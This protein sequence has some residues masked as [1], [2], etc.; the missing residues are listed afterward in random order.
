MPQ[1]AQHVTQEQESASKGKLNAIF[2][3]LPEG[4]AQRLFRQ[5][6][7]NL[8]N[9]F[10]SNRSLEFTFIKDL[11]RSPLQVVQPNST[12]EVTDGEA[13][14]IGHFEG[15][16]RPTP[17]RTAPEPQEIQEPSAPHSIHSSFLSLTPESSDLS[18]QSSFL[19]STTSPATPS[20][21]SA[22]DEANAINDEG[23]GQK[24]SS[25]RRKRINPEQ[26]LKVDDF[27]YSPPKSI[28][29]TEEQS[30]VEAEPPQPL[31]KRPS[32]IQVPV[33]R[34]R[35]SLTALHLETSDFNR[36]LSQ[37]DTLKHR[38]STLTSTYRQGQRSPDAIT[39]VERVLSRDR[40]SPP[41]LSPTGTKRTSVTSQQSASQP[42][43]GLRPGMFP[44]TFANGAGPTLVPQPAIT[45]IQ[46]HCYI[47]HAKMR[48]D[49]NKHYLT[50]C[51]TCG[52]VDDQVC[53]ICTFCFLRM[54]RKCYVEFDANGRIL[55]LPMVWRKEAKAG[56][57]NDQS[58]LTKPTE[59]NQ[60]PFHLLER[61][62]RKSSV[63]DLGKDEVGENWKGDVA[64]DSAVEA[65][66]AIITAAPVVE[67]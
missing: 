50:P 24:A 53:Q 48:E 15:L 44:K 66:G 60:P 8:R 62:L 1:E 38:A 28:E 26:R 45:E 12:A 46:R 41:V 37:Q 58:P 43:A 22:S 61:Q 4:N 29:A 52:N 65:E 54:C 14:K 59:E 56:T 57:A 40:L 10:P 23:M 47:K 6:I 33:P 21:L 31:R 20:N 49:A 51:M 7:S 42:S 27:S 5:S 3:R 35:S 16:S 17:Q 39:P 9:P 67:L 2:S 64:K 34:R 30:P 36:P 55:R 11:V 63:Q 19:T 25:I 18:N 13:D 32:S